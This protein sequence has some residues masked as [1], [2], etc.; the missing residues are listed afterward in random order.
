MLIAL[1][2]TL[3]TTASATPT[4]LA[5]AVPPPLPAHFGWGLAA[6]PPV[7]ANSG[8][9]PQSGIPWD[10]SYQYLA[11]GANTGPGGVGN[12]QAWNSNAQFPLWYAQAAGAHGYLPTLTYYNVLQSNGSCNACGEAQRD[13][14]NLNS[15]SVMSSVYADFTKLMQ[16]L[17][18]GNYDGIQGYGGA[19]I[20]HVEPDLSGYANQVTG[21]QPWASCYGYCSGAGNDPTLLNASVASSG[22]PDVASYPNNFAGFNW[23]LLHLRDVYAPNVV[24]AAHIS[25]WAPGPDIGRSTSPSLDMAALGNKAGSFMNAAGVVTSPPGTST[26]EL[27]FN[28]PLDRDAGFYT[29]QGDPG[30]WWDRLNFSFPNFARWEAYIA[31]LHATTGRPLIAWQVPI[32]NQWFQTVNNSTGHFQDNRS[33]YFFGHVSELVDSGLIAVMFG[34]GAGGQTTYGDTMGDGITNPTSFCTTAGVSSGQVCNNHISTVS[35]DDGGFIRMSAQAYYLSPWPLPVESGPPPAVLPPPPVSD[36]GW[37]LAEGTTR[38]EFDEY[39]T[40][41]NPY[42]EDAAVTLTYSLTSALDGA[43]STLVR[44][45]NVPSGRRSTVHVNES[46]SPGAGPNFDLS[47]SLRASVGGIVVER[48]MY[49]AGILGGIDGGHTAVAADAASKSWLFA[50]GTTRHGFREF[51]T[52]L[53]PE[54]APVEVTLTYSTRSGGPAGEAA[55]TTNTRLLPPASRTTVEVNNEIGENYDTSVEVA[56]AEPI[57][58]ERPIYFSNV[59]GGAND[60][61]V[62]VGARSPSQD[63]YF[64]EGY[65]GSGFREFVTLANPGTA[66]AT[67]NITVMPRNQAAFDLAPVSLAPT[68]RTTLD[69]N[70]LVGAGREF[71]L[72]LSSTQPIVAERPIYFTGV[73]GGINGGHDAVGAVTPALSWRFAEGY[74]GVGFREFVTIVNPQPSQATVTPTVLP[75][76]SAA[77]N[78]LP[79]SVPPGNRVTL[80]INQL[81]GPNQSIALNLESDQGIIA[82][83]PMYFSHDFGQ[84]PADGGSDVV[85]VAG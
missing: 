19:V 77:Y 78:L 63:W 11:G 81:V 79:I 29:S 84:G 35:D 58:A 67:V 54:P 43:H 18:P 52:M 45:L 72:H 41:S 59:F 44:T 33:E 17:G 40:I 23:A 10:Y 5:A 26:Y 9:M 21:N 14:S 56:A 53:N 70:A 12:W 22:N 30:R 16:R 68:S 55:V 83:R 82:E 48:P 49:F 57:V 38:P 80:D 15:S 75:S 36:H 64:A 3:S 47:T 32:G 62:A 65:T 4:P 28:D 61:H 46:A 73:L 13:L 7:V 85:G 60:G 37:Y 8:W 34:P 69:M 24:M 31:A 76:G 66:T 25:D 39:I 1:L 20:V 2:P 50:E 74:T 27:V 71:A 6:G 51:L 42:N